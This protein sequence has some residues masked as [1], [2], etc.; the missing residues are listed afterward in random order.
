MTT[1]APAKEYDVIVTARHPY[2]DERP[3]T[4]RVS[5]SSANE[6]I[7]RVRQDVS[8]ERTRADGSVTYRARVAVVGE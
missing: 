6:A 7:K 8:M 1:K 3:Y 5:A 4:V 2:H